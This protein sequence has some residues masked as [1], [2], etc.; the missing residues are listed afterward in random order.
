MVFTVYIYIC[1]TTTPKITTATFDTK[2]E[3]IKY[4]VDNL[5]NSKFIDDNSYEMLFD[6]I[7]HHNIDDIDNTIK[8]IFGEQTILLLKNITKID[9]SHIRTHNYNF[10]ETPTEIKKFKK[11]LSI[12]VLKEYLKKLEKCEDLNDFMKIIDTDFYEDYDEMVRK[13]GFSYKIIE[14]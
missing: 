5:I 7:D 3:V 14:S 1:T 8:K 4:L 10:G 12:D 11:I 2:D 13:E 9:Y 6:L